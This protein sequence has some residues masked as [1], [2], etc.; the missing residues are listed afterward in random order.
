[1]S[2][3]FYIRSNTSIIQRLTIYFVTQELQTEHLCFLFYAYSQSLAHIS[4]LFK[5]IGELCLCTNAFRRWYDVREHVR[6]LYRACNWYDCYHLLVYKF[7]LMTKQ[8]ITEGDIKDIITVPWISTAE[9]SSLIYWN[10]NWN[11]T[12]FSILRFW[13]KAFH[14]ISDVLFRSLALG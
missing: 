7:L 1:M 11:V 2:I 10:S 6:L 3:S 13:W 12:L 9:I 4:A 8:L 14:C 5:S